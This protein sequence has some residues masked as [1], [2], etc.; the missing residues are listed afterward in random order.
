[1]P[2]CDGFIIVCLIFT[3]SYTL[4]FYGFFLH[5]EVISRMKVNKHIVGNEDDFELHALIAIKPF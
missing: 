1:M 4:L 3:L 5:N 2:K